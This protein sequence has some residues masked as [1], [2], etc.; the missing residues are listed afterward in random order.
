MRADVELIVGREPVELDERGPLVRALDAAI[1][2]RTG[3][4]PAHVG[5]MGWADSGLLAQAGIPCAIFGPTGDGHHTAQEYVE[6]DSLIAC[7]DII[8]A[9]ARAFCSV[10]RV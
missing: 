7:A 9:T 1:Q 8:E 6:L 5:D 3:R 2:A 10:A 4:A